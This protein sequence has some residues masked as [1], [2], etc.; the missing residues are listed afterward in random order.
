MNYF[1]HYPTNIEIQKIQ[2]LC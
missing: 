2:H 1:Y